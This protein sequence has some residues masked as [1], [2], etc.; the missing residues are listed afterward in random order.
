MSGKAQDARLQKLDEMVRA[1]NDL[2]YKLKYM[3]EKIEMKPFS[4][5][6]EQTIEEIQHDL[7]SLEIEIDAFSQAA[8][9]G[10]WAQMQQKVAVTVFRSLCHQIDQIA[11][12]K[13]HMCMS[14]PPIH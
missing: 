7:F 13:K 6:D 3:K 5:R 12:D 9:A 8:Q 10:A 14:Q 4:Q 2:T 1:L 11:D